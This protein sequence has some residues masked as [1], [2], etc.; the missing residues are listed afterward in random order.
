MFLND[1]STCY[2]ARG[3]K[4]KRNHFRKRNQAKRR[5]PLKVGVDTFVIRLLDYHNFLN[6]EVLRNIDIFPNPA[7]CPD[8]IWSNG[9]QLQKGLLSPYIRQYHT[10][11]Y[12]TANVVGHL[13]TFRL[14]LSQ[15][16]F[17]NKY[18]GPVI[19]I[20]S[21][22][23]NTISLLVRFFPTRL[24]RIQIIIALYIVMRQVS[25]FTPP[26]PPLIYQKLFQFGDQ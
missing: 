15:S 14:L 9:I 19:P 23:A 25:L 4:L 8:C 20:I 3:T 22:L 10:E 17:R 7:W 2:C 21:E 13:T 11:T 26:F 5:L 1:A 24:D 6:S 12:T 16:A 18:I